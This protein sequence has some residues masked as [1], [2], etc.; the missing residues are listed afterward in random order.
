MNVTH[1]PHGYLNRILRVNLTEQTIKVEELDKGF[2][3][4]YLGGRSLALYYLLKETKPNIDPFSEA[5]L[6]IFATGALTGNAGPAIPRYTVVT[7]SPLTGGLGAS[8]AGGFWGPEL[9][10]AGYD[11]LIIEGVAKRPVYI[12]IKDDSVEIKDAENVWGLGSCE[13]QEKIKDEVGDKRARV[14][15]IGPGGEKLVR[16]ANIG[17]ELGHY[18]GRNGLGAVMGSKNLKAIAV[19]GSKKL[20]AFDEPKLKEIAKEFAKTFKENNLGYTL[21]EYGTTATVEALTGF[22]ALPTN[23][24]ETGVFEGAENLFADV[25]NEKL[26]TGR[27]G[28][29]ACPVRCKRVVTVKDEKYKV[30]SKY[31]GP[32]YETIGAMGPNMGIDDLNIIAKANELAN[33]YGL[34]TISLGMTISFATKCF[35]EGL[36]SVEDTGGLELKFGDGDALLAAIE[37]IAKREGFGDIMAEGSHIMAKRL[38]KGT[39][40]YTIT[41]KGQEAPMHDP[42]TKVGVGL[43][44]ATTD[45]GTDHMVAPHD[46]FLTDAESWSFKNAEKLGV[47]DPSG[48][49]DLTETKVKNFAIL[50]RYY[51]MFDTIGCCCFGFA[52]RGPMEVDTFLEMINAI[53][54]WETDFDELLKAG[55]RSLVLSRIY[56]YR[57]G[58]TAADDNLPQIFYKDMTDGPYKGKLAIDKDKFR[59]LIRSFYENLNWD[60]DTGYPKKEALESLGLGE[61]A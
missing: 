59:E 49:F 34:D 41:V 47:T 31:G 9:K 7:K 39:E 2:I 42:R 56:N 11:A 14:A 40:K 16:F 50:N 23:N 32:E 10:F 54:G 37:L 18:N 8:E 26:L 57:E 13:A 3:R 33:H 27:K 17:N 19:R 53:T 61:F 44:Y 51:R 24:W 1:G 6:L 5:N 20:K 43:A 38:G 30:N 29:Y 28:C 45:I 15:I 25:Y 22:G 52:P 48:L 46:G 36:I 60:K 12:W 35:E 55:E 4:K 21:F 58:F